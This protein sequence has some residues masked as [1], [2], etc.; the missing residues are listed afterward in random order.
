MTESSENFTRTR[1]DLGGPGSVYICRYCWGHI[2]SKN[3]W[4]MVCCPCGKSA[5]DG[6]DSYTKISA[7]EIPPDPLDI[8]RED[9]EAWSELECSCPRKWDEYTEDEYPA[10]ISKSEKPKMGVDGRGIFTVAKE[11]VKKYGKK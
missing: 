2:Q 8:H 6:G 11:M 7:S 3:R 4:D 9:C 1:N 5:V 10:R